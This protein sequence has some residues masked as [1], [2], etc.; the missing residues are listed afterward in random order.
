MRK[1]LLTFFAA[2]LCAAN[3]WAQYSGSCGTGLTWEYNSSEHSL[4]IS[5]SGAMSDYLYSNN[6]PW[7]SYQTGIRYVYISSGVS[8]IG[9]NAFYVCPLMRDFYACWDADELSTLSIGVNAFPSSLSSCYLHVPA[10]MRSNYNS[11]I[12]G[13]VFIRFA[14]IM[15]IVMLVQH[16]LP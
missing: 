5:G 6:V 8:Y 10:G 15:I 3:V 13:A 16:V 7:F 2:L 12:N 4:T 1:I 9:R 14:M 11:I